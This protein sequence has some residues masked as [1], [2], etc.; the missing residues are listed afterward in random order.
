[1]IM[2]LLALA[3]VGWLLVSA[4]STAV[5][6]M[7]LYLIPLQLFVFAR[8]PDLMGRGRGLRNWVLAVVAYYAAV[9]FVWLN[10]AT[11]AYTWVPYHSWLFL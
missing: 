2:A 4:S 7:A 1:M 9:L 5:D 3:S 8:L 11:H 6:R 10:F